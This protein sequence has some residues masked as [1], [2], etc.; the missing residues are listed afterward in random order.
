M[1]LGHPQQRLYRAGLM[2]RPQ[3]GRLLEALLVSLIVGVA[4]FEAFRGLQPALSKFGMLNAISLSRAELTDTIVG[5]AATGVPPE[6]VVSSPRANADFA[7]PRW[8]DGELVFPAAARLLRR[9]D[10]TERDGAELAFRV[11]RAPVSGATVWLCGTESPPPG[12][13]AAP[14]THTTIPSRYL[15]HFCR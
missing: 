15:P 5:M 8:Q 4:I 7:S 3:R 10:R 6:A 11:G 13:E 1:T 12:F 2:G 14:A 9:I